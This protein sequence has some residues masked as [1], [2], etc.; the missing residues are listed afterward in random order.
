[1]RL[2]DDTLLKKELDM[3]E[4]SLLKLFDNMSQL[5]STNYYKEPISLKDKVLVYYDE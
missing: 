4:E 3:N 5:S 2:K 1:M